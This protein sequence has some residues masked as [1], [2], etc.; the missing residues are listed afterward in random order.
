VLWVSSSFP[1]PGWV[2]T[3]AWINQQWYFVITPGDIRGRFTIIT[4][5]ACPSEWN[6]LLLTIVAYFVRNYIIVNV[7][8]S[9]NCGLEQTVMV[10]QNINIYE[11]F[12]SSWKREATTTNGCSQVHIVQKNMLYYTNMGAGLAGHT[13]FLICLFN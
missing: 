8:L 6:L 5:W 7:L 3:D 4:L 10:I 11:V 13:F 2:R 1:A 12:F 9:W